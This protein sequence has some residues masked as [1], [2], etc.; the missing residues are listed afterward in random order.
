METKRNFANV[1]RKT[2]VSGQNLQHFISNS[3]W[4]AESLIEAIQSEIKVHPAFQEAILVL[5]E[6][7]EEKAGEGSAGAGRQHNGRLGKIE[8]SQVGVFLSL[9]T[10]QV[11]TWI[12]GE[13]YIPAG[14]FE[15]GYGEQR[16]AVGIPEQRSFQKKPELGW[17]LIQRAQ[18][19]GVPFQA[20]VMDDLY[21]RNENL[22]QRL[23]QAG[24]EYYGDVPVDTRV[25]LEP[26]AIVYPL[27]KRGQPA[28]NPQ[29]QGRSYEV[30]E[31]A[32]H[33]QW[34][35]I[36]LRPNERGY[37]QADFGRCRV[38]VVYGTSLRQEWLLVRKDATQVTYA[39]S[40]APAEIP[41]ETMAWRKTHRYLIE[42]SNEDAKGEFGWDEFQARKYRAWEH[43]LAL[44]ILA[45]W[46]V[47]ETR[48]DWMQRFQR[49]PALL[50]KYE[51]DV[52]PQLSVGNVRDLLRAAM[53][54]PQLSP[55][56]ATQL[57]TSHLINRTRSRKS[58]LRKARP[59]GQG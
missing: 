33:L 8:M 19:R 36:R 41:L 43:Q 34:Q 20:V 11:N 58:R 18:A 49:D 6:S 56:D 24:I 35:T 22:R 32:Q 59:K 16:K 55:E 26:P 15:A 50:A 44:T 23:D 14:W 53:P 38:W 37:L 2:E 30:Q 12:D 40:N 13:L 46:F 47:A 54:L 28:K 10:P 52:L 42:R 29:I 4:S 21:G 25:Y 7:A 1:G 17:Q 45:A 51:V 3:P 39:L 48:L 31:L 57:V 9:V 27:T 5:D